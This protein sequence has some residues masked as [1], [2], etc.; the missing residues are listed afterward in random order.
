MKT[1][2]D[3]IIPFS[4]PDRRPILLDRF[5]YVPAK[6]EYKR[7]TIPFFTD[8][9][10]VI[11]EYCSGNGQWIGA[12]A[13]QNP[14]LNWL[15]VEKRFERARQIWLLSHREK[16]PNLAV[17]C[18]EGFVF[19]RFYAPK[20]REVFINFPDPWPKLRHAKHRIVQ[21]PFLQEVAGIV[22]IGGKATCV[23]DDPAYS[24]QMV[25]EFE[26]VPS[27]RFLFNVHE[28]PDYG[29]SFFNDLW[30]K[31]GRNIHY[32]SYERI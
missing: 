7:E 22:E 24:G 2:K 4:W 10:P 6:Y 27:W 31:R 5:F 12:R 28:W 19:T 8:E 9:R 14:H 16:L 32:I 23:T 29:R 25:K 20:A 3:L 11:I 15:A 17:A 13:K 21:T 26:R 30:T 1:A 18:C